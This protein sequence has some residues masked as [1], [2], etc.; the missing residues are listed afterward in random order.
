MTEHRTY[1]VNQ[2]ESA[3]FN[4]RNEL[5]EKI[6]V[7]N[8]HGCSIHISEQLDSINK[9]ESDSIE[10]VKQTAAVGRKRLEEL[11]AHHFH[12]VK[13]TFSALSDQVH[14]MMEEESFLENDIEHLEQKF[15]KL[16]LDMENF[17]LE[18]KINAL[19]CESIDVRSKTTS[20]GHSMKSGSESESK[21]PPKLYFLDWLLTVAK[22]KDSID[23][24]FMQPGRVLS[25]DRKTIS[26][27]LKNQISTFNLDA[28]SWCSMTC[29]PQT[30]EIHWSDHLEVFLYLEYSYRKN[31]P[32]QLFQ[33]D[34][35]SSSCK[36]VL[37]KDDNWNS[38]W[39]D[40]MLTLACFKQNIVIVM[41]NKIELW[42]ASR[43]DWH[44]FS[45]NVTRWYPP[46]A[47]RSGTEIKQIR[48]ND[49]YYALLAEINCSN[50]EG[51]KTLISLE[52]E[53]RNHGMSI[54]HCIALK[55]DIFGVQMRFCSLPKA[56]GWLFFTKNN[57]VA[58][59]YIIGNDGKRYEQSVV[60]SCDVDDIVVFENTIVFRKNCNYG[61]TDV[62]DIY[63]WYT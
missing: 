26:F 21:N 22:P 55:P 14:R 53:I 31:R 28:R 40:N 10:L 62:V 2:L 19:S 41:D 42:P 60:L 50:E 5:G 48:M 24:T 33:Y 1:L 25:I 18:L 11:A 17:P 57:D 7:C 15:Q 29:Y 12:T 43:K 56:S 54:L 45:G 37:A 52:L 63:D 44:T 16:K 3:V 4:Q 39:K 38:G 61:Y 8:E 30:H 27:I 51:A 20:E 23:L 9:W 35:K 32:N 46:V 59:C 49:S 6:M 13:N 36:A 47:W 34:P 58:C